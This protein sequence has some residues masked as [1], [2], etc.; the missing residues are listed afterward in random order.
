MERYYH[1]LLVCATIV[2]D[3]LQEIQR[4]KPILFF[5]FLFPCSGMVAMF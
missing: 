2:E 3:A 5:S 4:L 1:Y